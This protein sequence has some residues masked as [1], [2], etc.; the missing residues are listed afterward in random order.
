MSF[1]GADIDGL[2][3]G[4]VEAGTWH[5]V[6]A[7]VVDRDGVLYEGAAGEAKRRRCFATPR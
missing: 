2:L 4:A 5:G 7:V 6:V 1:D 3:R